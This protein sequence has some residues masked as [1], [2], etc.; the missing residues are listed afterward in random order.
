MKPL[1]L[2][3]VVLMAASAWG[4]TPTETS[5]RYVA[6]GEGDD[7]NDGQSWKTAKNTLRAGLYDGIPDDVVPEVHLRGR[8][9]TVGRPDH[10]GAGE[11][12]PGEDSGVLPPQ[13]AIVHG[14][15]LARLDSECLYEHG[16][17]SGRGRG[18]GLTRYVIDGVHF[19]SSGFSE[20]TVELNNVRGSGLHVENVDLS[21]T[22]SALPGGSEPDDGFDFRSDGRGSLA[23]TD[24]FLASAGHG[25]ALFL[26]LADEAAQFPPV[27][28]ERNVIAAAGNVIF[29]AAPHTRL[30]VIL[31]E[32]RFEWNAPHLSFHAAADARILA[33]LWGNVFTEP[34]PRF[35]VHGEVTFAGRRVD[36]EPY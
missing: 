24:S 18:P 14:D 10:P 22:L 34:P 1:S 2:L 19:E 21:M 8:C 5:V 12:L 13:G 15:G 9:V 20:A 33:I 29:D 23:I 25:A 16:T 28:L 7:A 32:N 3:L 6:C 36:W 4:A 17:L 35:E 26:T 11:C 27:R 30:T 31:R